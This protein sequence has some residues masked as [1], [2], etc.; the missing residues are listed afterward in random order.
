MPVNHV[1]AGAG[2]L[3]VATGG[4]A[5]GYA[6]VQHFNRQLLDPDYWNKRKVGYAVGGA[7]VGAVAC[8]AIV[9]GGLKIAGVSILKHAAVPPLLGVAF[10][11]D[12]GDSDCSEEELEDALG[13]LSDE[14]VEALLDS[15]GGIDEATAEVKVGPRLAAPSPARMEDFL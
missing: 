15:A 1:M 8:S 12:R 3:S 7:V 2:A 6:A 9:C 5:G 14:T 4:V 13:S 11:A 10:T